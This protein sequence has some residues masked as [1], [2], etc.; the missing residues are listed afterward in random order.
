MNL[1]HYESRPLFK[2][3]FFALACFVITMLFVSMPCFGIEAPVFKKKLP[4]GLL[5][6]QQPSDRSD[7]VCVCLV[8]KLS[9]FDEREQK[10]G[11]RALLGDLLLEKICSRTSQKG[12]RLIEMMGVMS[13]A[14]TTPDYMSLS[15]ITTPS[16]YKKIIEMVAADLQECSFDEALYKREKDAYR[17]RIE[18]GKSG[19]SS[20]YDIFLQNFYRYHPYKLSEEAN[21]KGLQSVKKEDL[22]KFLRNYLSS[23]RVVIAVTGNVDPLEVTKFV[24]QSFSKLSPKT[25]SR[26]EVQWEPR[27]TQ[28]EVFLSSLSQMAYLL[29]G[30]PAPSYGSPDFP[31]MKVLQTLLGEGLNSRLWIQLREK[32]GLA[33][34][35]GSFYPELE[36][37][38]HVLIYV[39]AQPQNI[40]LVRRIINKELKNI[41]VNG[42]SSGELEDAKAKIYGS[43]LLERESVKGCAMNMVSA[44]VIGGKY[45]LD[46]TL[47]RNIEEVN[48]EDI[49]RVI[50]RYFEEPTLLVV[51][52][53]G[54]FYIDWFE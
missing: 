51:R 35:L 13:N 34:S 52:P 33:Y 2:G 43:L 45:G 23:D 31:A 37:P 47:E 21:Y 42:V 10:V 1:L 9:V 54:H 3:R 40:I 18:G 48:S 30:F 20:I 5:V 16:D 24:E 41:Q 50:T 6:L 44:E 39:V 19:F 25:S 15:F 11:I 36:G 38:S 8:L 49:R 29:M 32:R 14:E 22:E 4:N 53:P 26:V 12:I 46:V 28:K 17:E 27:A 7:I